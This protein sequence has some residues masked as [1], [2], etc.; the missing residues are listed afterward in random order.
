MHFSSY[1]RRAFVKK[2]YNS[3]SFLIVF[4][5]LTWKCD[6]KCYQAPRLFGNARRRCFTHS[7]LVKF[8]FEVNASL[9]STLSNMTPR[10]VCGEGWTFN[11]TGRTE[12]RSSH[13][14]S[15]NRR[16]RKSLRAK[17]HSVE[18]PQL[19]APLHLQLRRESNDLKASSFT[20]QRRMGDFPPRFV[21]RR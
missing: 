21:R 17:I 7:H 12:G 4:Q 6:S 16:R 2:S 19:C 11:L 1:L 18:T 5:Y 8:C 10:G 9:L 15:A 3:S 20:F 13:S 14:G